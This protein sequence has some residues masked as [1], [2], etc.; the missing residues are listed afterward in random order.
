[1]KYIPYQDILGDIK[2]LNI[3]TCLVDWDATQIGNW[4]YYNLTGRNY[5]YL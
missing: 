2:V 4:F 5:T 3:V 1:M